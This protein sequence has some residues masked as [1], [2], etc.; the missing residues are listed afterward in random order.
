MPADE[1]CADCDY[2]SHE[3]CAVC[4]VEWSKVTQN[5]PYICLACRAKPVLR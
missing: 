2:R 3:L 1:M 5:T 4:R